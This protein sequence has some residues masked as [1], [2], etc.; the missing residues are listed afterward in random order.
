MKSTSKHPIA[1][2]FPKAHKITGEDVHLTARDLEM[3]FLL[4]SN[5]R[6]KQMAKPLSI[7]VQTVYNC[8]SALKKKTGYYHAG[9]ISFAHEFG[10]ITSVNKKTVRGWKKMKDGRCYI[11]PKTWNPVYTGRKFP[12]GYLKVV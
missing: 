7:A 4:V 10:I 12:H 3:I 11:D 2:T 9:I 1:I 6:Y 5:H 8:S